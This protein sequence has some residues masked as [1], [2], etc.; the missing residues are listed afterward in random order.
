MSSTETPVRPSSE[1]SEAW[2]AEL[3]RM[4]GIEEMDEFDKAGKFDVEEEQR[5]F[6]GDVKGS[7]SSD[8]REGQER[9]NEERDKMTNWEDYI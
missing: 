7:K 1:R 5:L 8:E 4:W 3:R 2:G 6:G 9:W